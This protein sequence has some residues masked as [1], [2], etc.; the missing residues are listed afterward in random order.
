MSAGG[1]TGSRCTNTPAQ[2]LSGQRVVPI[3]LTDSEEVVVE[4]AAIVSWAEA[5][6]GHPGV[7]S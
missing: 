4:S 7:A 5:H 6:P 3:P 1:S 2:K